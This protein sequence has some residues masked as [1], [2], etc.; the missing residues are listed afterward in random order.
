MNRTRNHVAIYERLTGLYPAPFRDEYRSDLV[1]LF[2][3]QMQDESPIRVWL[4]ALRDLAV[5]VPTLQLEVRMDRPSG[6]IVTTLF[7]I[8]TAATALLAVVSGSASTALPFLFIAIAT[9]AVAYWSFSASRS[10]RPPGA[11]SQSWWKFLLAGVGL[12][13]A[14]AIAVKIPWPA[15]I[16]LGDLSYWLVVIS[17]M[18]SITLA[19]SG[20]VLGIGNLI[21]RQRV[22][23]TG[24]PIA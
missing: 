14:T 5:T 19:G 4:R 13:V 17:G 8:A 6:N 1:A 18:M 10:A 24:A 3:A 16:D 12:A 2:D 9:G 20:I 21:R 23:G 7:S 11:V 15:A 22:S